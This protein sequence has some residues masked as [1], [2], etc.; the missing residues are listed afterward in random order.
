MSWR[1]PSAIWPGRSSETV[2]P[3]RLANES[4]CET[5]SFDC[6]TDTFHRMATDRAIPLFEV[7]DI[8]R[9]RWLLLGVMCLSLVLVVM[10]VSSLNV[11][12]PRLQQDLGATSTQLHWIIDSYALVFAGLLLSA[13]ALGDRFGRKGA[14]LGGLGVFGAGLLVAGLGTTAGQVIAGRSIMGIGSAFVMPA[15]QAR[16]ALTANCIDLVDKNDRRRIILGRLE[17]IPD[18][19]GADSDKHLDELAAVDRIEGHTRFARDGPS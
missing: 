4:Q 5:E 9:R 18:A 19:A 12:A 2:F 1:A 3:F 8:H 17:Q 7:P 16:T 14:L 10:S 15:T 13:G 6:A 11:A